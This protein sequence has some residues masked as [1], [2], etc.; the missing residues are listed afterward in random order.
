MGPSPL[1]R[2]LSCSVLGW[3]CVVYLVASLPFRFSSTP[4]APPYGFW[5][6]LRANRRKQ[7]RVIT[8]NAE[9]VKL[10]TAS[11]PAAW[12]RGTLTERH[13]IQLRQLSGRREPAE[14]ARR[15][16]VHRNSDRARCRL[17]PSNWLTAHCK[18]RL[19][20]CTL[21]SPPDVSCLGGGIARNNRRNQSGMSWRE[22]V[23]R[24][25]RDHA[26]RGSVDGRPPSHPKESDDP[27]DGHDSS[28]ASP[29]DP[30]L[31]VSGAMRRLAVGDVDRSP[32]CEEAARQTRISSTPRGTTAPARNQPLL[33]QPDLTVGCQQNSAMVG[34]LDFGEQIHRVESTLRRRRRSMNPVPFRIAPRRA[35]ST[36]AVVTAALLL[37]PGRTPLG[38][39]CRRPP[40]PKPWTGGMW[41][42]ALGLPIPSLFPPCP[43][44]ACPRTGG[45]RPRGLLAGIWRPLSGT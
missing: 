5:R 11:R 42:F 6:I 43:S 15:S 12:G 25:L 18:D 29:G 45:G 37:T 27:D 39:T 22:T 28:C 41:S 9:R 24:E 19:Q 3:P 31:N 20:P 40:R 38:Q 2:T 8:P 7:I 16:A 23:Q 35:T 44:V 26:P 36:G 10:S 34:P 4:K 13:A 21:G 17:H 30:G 32:R 1:F 14:E 33:H